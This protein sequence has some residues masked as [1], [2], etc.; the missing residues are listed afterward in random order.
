M[1]YLAVNIHC[2]DR[3]DLYTDMKLMTMEHKGHD[4]RALCILTS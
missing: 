3:E 2:L 1:K 4:E